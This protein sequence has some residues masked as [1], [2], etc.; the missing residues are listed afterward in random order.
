[1]K[2][3]S[4]FILFFLTACG[5]N[6]QYAYKQEVSETD[7]LMDIVYQRQ[8]VNT[9]TSVI[10][11]IPVFNQPSDSIE[12]TGFLANP[13]VQA[14]IQYH[15]QN[16]GLD[17]DYLNDFFA[18]ATYRGNIINIMN[19]PG[20]S[21]PWYEFQQNNAGMAKIQAGKRFYQQH[22]STIDR[23][24]VQYG[25]PAELIVA[26]IGIETN[27]GRYTGNIR[28]GDSLS[29]LAFAYP[30]RAAFFQKE[31]LEFLKLAQEEQQDPFVF[32][33]SYAGAMGMPQFMPSS[34][35]QWVVDANNDGHRDIWGDVADTAA[36]VAHYLKQHGWQTG[37]RMII[38][39]SLTMTPQ[40]QAVIDEKTALTYSV[41]QLRQMGV[42]LQQTVAEDEKAVLYALEVAPKQFNYYIGLNNFYTVWQYNHSRMYVTAVRDIANGIADKGL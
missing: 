20:T 27:Y 1:M 35:R 25:V 38:P 14:F 4:V 26:I 8:I 40:L 33:G 42:V 28:V 39:V 5:Y 16:S 29:T 6:Q 10:N 15:H 3:Y 37:K 19:R 24:A 36:S 31:L 12:K 11:P 41:A 21:R 7:P 34:F 9:Q 17:L 22:Q 32:T 23:I 13:N 2:K 18:R 30:R